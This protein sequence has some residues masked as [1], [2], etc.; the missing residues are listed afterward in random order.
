MEKRWIL[1]E[2]MPTEISEALVIYPAPIRQILFN[3]GCVDNISAQHFLDGKNEIADPFLLTGMQKTVERLKKAIIENDPIAIY[4]DYDVDGV[5]ATTLLVECLQQLGGNVRGYIPNR[6]DEGYGLNIEALELLRKDGVTVVVTVDCGIRSLREADHAKELG[7]DLIISD[8]HHPKDELPDAY[9]V[10]CQK[11]EGDQYLF[12]DLAGVGLAYKIAQGLVTLFLEKGIHVE[13][14]LDLVALGTVADVVPLQGENRAF[15]K[16]GIER[17][18]HGTRVG[19]RALANVAGVEID[20]VNTSDIGFALAPRLNAAGRLESALAALNLLLA[21]EISQAAPLAFQLDTQNRERQKVT[22]EIQDAAEAMV[23]D[24]NDSFLLYAAH[25]EFNQGV[26]GLAASRLMENHYR[27]AIVASI[28][29]RETRGSC[30]SIPEF[31]VTRALDEVADL[32]VR[33]GGHAMAAGFTIRNENTA[34][35]V[36][37]MKMI[38]AREIGQQEL[39][40]SL[41]IDCEIPLRDLKPGLLDYLALIQP[42]G[43]SNP[44]PLFISK[45]LRV[46]QAKT[47]GMDA[48]HLKMSLTDDLITFDAIAFRFGSMKDE[49]SRGR[50]DAVYSFE[51]NVFNGIAKLQL[52]V[53][54]VKPTTDG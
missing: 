26:V 52:N 7:I 16:A 37:K 28:S 20:R 14:W 3:R 13:E 19:L 15:V 42:T 38:A 6:F 50:V 41:H 33:H 49:L 44:E 24:Q 47:V 43:M 18:H 39:K 29:E 30:R 34:L 23:I 35:F 45:N 32:L 9:S 11:Q 8:H 27:P 5:T 21:K 12:K 10:I 48:K 31:H 53:R 54:D 46:V 36:E 51:K 40:P 1:H 2:R 22:R 4:G 17:I 25:T